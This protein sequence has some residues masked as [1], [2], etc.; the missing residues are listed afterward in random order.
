MNHSNSIAGILFDKDGTLL[1]FNGTW[2]KPYL[3]ASEF[4][5]NSVERPELASELMKKGGYCQE[6]QT[7]QTDSLLASGSNG[8]IFDF[9]QTEMGAPLTAEQV[10]RVREIFSHAADAYVPAIDDLVG[11]LDK[12]RQRNLMIGLATMDD[13]SNAEG[14][15][16]QLEISHYF[17]FVCG[18]DS[19]FGVKP[20][21]GMVEA[22]CRYCNVSADQ[23]LMVGDSPKDL[24]M[25]RNAGVQ[26]SVGVLTGAHSEQELM[27]YADIVLADISELI[28][29]L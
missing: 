4:L 18:A 22:F 27:R 6:T 29:L 19:G 1:D 5:A 7:W 12:L 11:F 25:G 2:L 16:E 10:A 20:E 21:P 13:I 26:Q 3:L 15:L 23:I 9:W 14:M 24:N 28:G 8:Q 17:D